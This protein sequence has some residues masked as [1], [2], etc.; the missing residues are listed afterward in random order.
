[1]NCSW[2]W[3]CLRKRTFFTEIYSMDA[4]WNG[5]WICTR[6]H[7]NIF[8]I[9]CYWLYII[10]PMSHPFSHYPSIPID[11]LW[12]TPWQEDSAL[13]FSRLPL[14]D[15]PQQF[16]DTRFGVI[17]PTSYPAKFLYRMDWNVSS[18]LYIYCDMDM[19]IWALLIATMM[20]ALLLLSPADTISE[21]LVIWGSHY[22][23]QS[24]L[25]DNFRI[26]RTATNGCTCF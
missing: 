9:N 10:I 12:V 17:R 8:D 14:P 16:E 18:L 6:H 23:H 5:S 1:M 22:L 7:L 15:L 19:S 3:L 13:R 20:R 26:P 4:L 25:Q 11:D 24:C 2:P 21:F